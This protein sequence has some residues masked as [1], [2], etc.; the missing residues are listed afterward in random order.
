MEHAPL[1][2][3][4]MPLPVHPGSPLPQPA[5]LPLPAAADG[6]D[7]M[8]VDDLWQQHNAGDVPMVPVASPPP[9]PMLQPGL[10]G[11]QA[12]IGNLANQL[13]GGADPLAPE[14]QAALPG[15]QGALDLLANA[16][17]QFAQPEEPQLIN[18]FNFHFHFHFPPNDD[19]VPPQ[20]FL[21]Q[22]A[23]PQQQAAAQAAELAVQLDHLQ[24][25]HAAPPVHLIAALQ[26]AL[27]PHAQAPVP[28]AAVPAPAP[29]HAVHRKRSLTD[30][31]PSVWDVKDPVTKKAVRCEEQQVS[32]TEA[33]EE[34]G[35][36]HCQELASNKQPGR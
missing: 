26:Q 11:L 4:I 9:P 15:I 5:P 1:I 25:Q 23:A 17:A 2:Q 14:F 22:A 7:A 3:N 16:D 31:E 28:A 20:P 33:F 27:G 6:D 10:E 13:A 34:G 36:G 35:G 29:S 21:N 8:E 30:T 32:G 19:D 12:F 18:D 24:A